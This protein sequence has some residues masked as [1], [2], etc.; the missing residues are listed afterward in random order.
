MW[1][2]ALFLVTVIL[3]TPDGRTAVEQWAHQASSL[4]A[5]NSTYGD[6]AIAA[7]A[8]VFVGLFL[9]LL[10]QSPKDPNHLWILQRVQGPE[11]F[12]MRP[13]PLRMA[14]GPKTRLPR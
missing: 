2:P 5:G 4:F 14:S 7:M 1:K 8:L 9:L 6:L 12:R 10:C 3:V 13:D 11:N